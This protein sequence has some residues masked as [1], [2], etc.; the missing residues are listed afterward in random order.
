M[1]I[2][3]I[4]KK[5]WTSNWAC[6]LLC[7]ST[8]AGRTVFTSFLKSEFSQENIDFWMACQ[9]YK[10]TS[11]AKLAARARKIYQQYVEA[12]APNEVITPPWSTIKTPNVKSSAPTSSSLFIDGPAG[13]LGCGDQR[14]NE[15]ERG[16]RLPEL[17]RRSP[18]GHLHLDGERL[19]QALPSFQADE[20]AQPKLPSGEHRKKKL[21]LVGEESATSWRRLNCEKDGKSKRKVQETETGWECW[22]CLSLG[23]IGRLVTFGPDLICWK[24]KYTHNTYIYITYLQ[25]MCWH[26]RRSCWNL[27]RH[28]VTFCIIT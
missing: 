27:S 26:S 11:P 19:V 3:I 16:R 10:K 8:P 15:A 25:V 14:G 22:S 2:K 6:N 1:N 21:Q 28:A 17:F 24:K 18:E 4:L 13:E 20:R 9:D 23:W 5:K 7:V 12:D